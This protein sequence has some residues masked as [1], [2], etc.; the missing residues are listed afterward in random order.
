M[1]QRQSKSGVVA[2]A[3]ALLAVSGCAQ[4]STQRTLRAIPV[5]AP[6][7]VVVP[8]GAGFAIRGERSGDAVVAHVDKIERCAD[9]L[10]QNAR[11]LERTERKAVGYSLLGEWLIGSLVTA[12]GAT[13]LGLTAAYPPE[14]SVT[15]KSQ[16]TAWLQA[17]AVTAVGAAILAGAIWDQS[18]V[19]ASERDLGVR[20]L[21]R[22]K[23]E[24]VCSA[25]P[26]AAAPVRLTLPD[27]EQLTATTDEAGVARIALPADL[28][29]RLTR[30][31]SRRA[32]LEA[33]G[34]ARAQLRISL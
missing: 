25:A 14:P 30:E 10:H 15:S 31:G 7:P 26:A 18:L 3:A 12:S 2:L 8:L 11:G 1:H 24:R 20:E 27:G 33:Q 23:A 6:R 21:R 5:E 9:E 13:L 32:T 19:G 22:R 4:L 17:G 28:E 16:T 29:A 34:D